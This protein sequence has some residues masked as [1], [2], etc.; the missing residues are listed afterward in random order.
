MTTRTLEELY[1]AHTG[2][3]SDK[4][5]SYLDEYERVLSIYRD[6]PI[7]LLEIGI[8]N[9]G[10]LEI[11][12][13]YFTSAARLIGCDINPDCSVLRYEDPRVAVVV[14]NAN[15]DDTQSEILKLSA[16]LDIII[17]DG[18]HRS[19]DIVQSFARYFPRVA[20]GGVFIAEDLHCSYWAEYEGGLYDPYSSISFFKRLADVLHHEHWGV[21]RPRAEVLRGFF[22]KYGVN[23]SEE[24]LACVH[25]IEFANSMCIIR[26]APEHRNALGR[27]VIAGNV[28]EVVPGMREMLARHGATPPES[29]NQNANAWSTRS[30]PPDEECPLLAAELAASAGRLLV[31]EAEI[32]AAKTELLKAA[33][34]VKNGERDLSRAAASIVELSIALGEREAEQARLYKRLEDSK[35]RAEKAQQALARSENVRA[36]LLASTS[37]RI[38]RPVRIAR[39]KARQLTQASKPS[40]GYRRARKILRQKGLV[41]AT[42][43]FIALWTGRSQAA[44]AQAAAGEL[45]IAIDKAPAPAAAIA[46]HDELAAWCDRSDLQNEEQR[47]ALAVRI[48]ALARK[49]LFSVVMRTFNPEPRSLVQAIESVRAQIYPYWELCIEDTASTSAIA[50]SILTQYAQKDERI[51]VQLRKRTKGVLDTSDDLLS[52]ATGELVALMDQDA[53]LREHALACVASTVNQRDGLRLIYS[54]EDSVNAQG[55]RITPYH[56]PDWNP[57]L[58]LSHNM[59]AHLGVYDAALLRE[60][61]GFP[62]GLEASADYELALRCTERLTPSE[63][64]HI[65]H[66]LYSARH[67]SD[68][69]AR[70][71]AQ[72]AFPLLAGQRALQEHFARCGIK[73]AVEPMPSGMYRV[74]YALPSPAP[75]VSLVL[76][77]PSSLASV[78]KQLDMLSE[79]TTY[80]NYEILVIDDGTVYTKSASKAEAFEGHSRAHLIRDEKAL[81]HAAANSA[82]LAAARGDLLCFLREGLEPISPSWLE[83]LV[84][85]ALQPGT[86]AVAPHIERPDRTQAAQTVKGTSSDLPDAA[87][88]DA[89][90]G[91]P[92]RAAVLQSIPTL[93]IGCVVLKRALYEEVNSLREPAPQTNAGNITFCLRLREAGYRNVWTPHAQLRDRSVSP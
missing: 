11:W 69:T 16:Q 19:S 84:S 6:R 42:K 38:T 45:S 78:K 87:P 58:F 23:L 90:A 17:D 85:I 33:K 5:S 61:G 2:K 80:P 15:T 14:G 27:R 76:S 48:G 20:P 24:E 37:W 7:R 62:V 21:P 49:P 70:G 4:W 75:L 93:P 25:S 57:E 52:H 71:R 73:A 68:K 29:A 31:L 9:G 44:P 59:L 43:H 88:V 10:S 13:Q 60:I 22:S 41:G 35:R 32:G 91:A 54:D 18:S 92:S 39:K 63:I 65:P 36:D 81:T 79:R 51:K 47:S 77:K 30:M 26:K 74:R 46:A 3:V 8:Q 67:R 53:I 82:A 64:H 86:G 89:P 72:S 55:K 66:V 83:E 50:R 28:E 1:A 12:A 56:K 40:T 34:V